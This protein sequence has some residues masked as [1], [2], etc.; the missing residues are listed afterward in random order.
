VHLKFTR[1]EDTTLIVE[2]TTNEPEGGNAMT[3]FRVPLCTSITCGII[4][5][6]TT[7]TTTIIMMMIMINIIIIR[8]T[9][10]SSV[11]FS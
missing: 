3:L 10:F 4:I 5:T 1:W 2:S 7:T 8:R 11:S 9:P 6:L